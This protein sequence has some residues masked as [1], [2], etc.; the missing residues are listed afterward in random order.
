MEKDVLTPEQVT[1]TQILKWTKMVTNIVHP[2]LV[3]LS[4]APL[5]AVPPSETA[6]VI[7]AKNAQQRAVM[8]Y[9]VC[10]QVVLVSCQMFLLLLWKTLMN[11]PNSQALVKEAIA[12]TALVL[13]NVPVH[14]DMN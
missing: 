11:V 6:G 2:L 4:F 10:A 12:L 5:A 7:L 8:S 13:T 3:H 1:A 9:I 14:L